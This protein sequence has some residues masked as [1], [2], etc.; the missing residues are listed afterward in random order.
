MCNPTAGGGG[1]MTG[2]RCIATHDVI[3]YLRDDDNTFS[4]YVLQREFSSVTIGLST[5]IY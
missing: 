4:P 2:T 3:L 5:P 1:L